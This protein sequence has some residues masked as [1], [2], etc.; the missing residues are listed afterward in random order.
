VRRRR[1]RCSNWLL[2]RSVSTSTERGECFALESR[3]KKQLEN[4]M[5]D[6]D[7][8]EKATKV[9]QELDEVSN[10]RQGGRGSADLP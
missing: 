3:V 1:L 7:G 5:V 6:R 10:G 9:E 8:G 2:R 4:L